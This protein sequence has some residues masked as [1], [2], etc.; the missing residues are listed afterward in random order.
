MSGISKLTLASLTELNILVES[1][2]D[3]PK[4][5]VRLERMLARRRIFMTTVTRAAFALSCS[6]LY[7]TPLLAQTPRQQLAKDKDLPSNAH[8]LKKQTRAQASTVIVTATTNNQRVRY[9]AM[10]EVHQTRLQVFS[11]DGIQ[12]YDSDFK[13]G[14]LIDWQLVDQQGQHL[15]DG[16]YLFLITIKDFSDALTQKYGIALLEQEEVSLSQST[17]AELTKG[18][19]TALDSNRQSEAFSAIDRIGAAGVNRTAL[20]EGGIVID[21]PSG[22]STTTATTTP[23]G[24]NIS[25]TGSQNKLA[26]WTDNAG[27]LG[28]SNIFE[29]TTGNIGVGISNPNPNGVL[30]INK[31]QNTGTSLFVTNNSTGSDAISSIRVGLNPSNY[32]V[33]DISI[34]ILGANWPA[35]HGGSFLKGRTTLLEADGSNFGIGSINNTE[36]FIFYTTTARTERMRI[37]ADGKV[38]IGTINP[39]SLLDV[40]GDINVSGN[41]IITGN[42]AA[43]Y[44]DVAEWVPTQQQ[45]TAGTVVILDGARTNSVVPSYRA[46]DTHIAGVVSAQPGL[47]LGEGGIGKVMVATT[48]R[49]KV[50]VDASRHPIRIGDLLVTSGESGVAMR[51]QPIRAGRTLIHRPGTII[52]KA[53]EPL[54]GGRGEILVLLSLQ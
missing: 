43:K 36:P 49:V 16:S 4:V 31:P 45:I 8:L 15:A 33:E 50:K 39:Q 5:M 1:Q 47:I 28:D 14:N 25:G 26:K 46:Y 7:F 19:A 18:Q 34:N 6:L 54:A 11:A 38:G 23:G 44:Q 20:T 52:G 27:T 30:H 37:T 32:A 17:A 3:S 2:S 53:L 9:V 22:K 35:G 13:L 12:V 21:A 48:G 40:A 10:G 42:I 51:S 41:A 24:V 29:G